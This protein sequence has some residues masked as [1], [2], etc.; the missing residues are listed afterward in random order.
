MKK[1][2][3]LL[4]AIVFLMTG[5]FGKGENE[6][7]AE[8]LEPNGEL[9]KL[10][11]DEGFKWTYTGFAEYYHEMKL[12]SITV[13]GQ[14]MIYRISGE[15]ED[16]SDGESSKDHGISLYYVVDHEKIVQKKQEETMMDSDFNE[17]TLIKMPLEKGTS[18]EESLVDKVGKT[19]TITS[20]IIEVA[21]DGG[22]TI[23]KVKYEEPKTDYYET[24]EIAADY[25]VI[26]FTRSV[27][28]DGDSY[29]MG[30]GLYGEQSGY[31]DEEDTA[32]KP[33]GSETVEEGDEDSEVSEEADLEQQEK[34]AVKVTIYDFN[35]S[36]IEYVNENDQEVF[37][38]VVKGGKAESN[39]RKFNRKNL[40]EEFLEMTVNE[41]YVNGD[42][43]TVNVYEK[44]KKEKSGTV[45]V[46][47]YNWRYFLRKID[48]VWLVDKYES[49]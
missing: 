48:G 10:L 44:I 6:V 34:E 31:I 33:E 11:P 39:A 7:S 23:Y 14:R 16:V 1:I 47:E 18:W 22:N 36:W 40:V 30:Y 29:T 38:Y 20:T 27:S 25:G 41:V 49:R 9:L 45:N 26:A 3:I 46:V 12:D 13:D 5:C 37:D 15:V 2:I 17:L 28:F 35:N 19:R 42:E 8:N 24:R 32:T 43:A 21:V 4:V